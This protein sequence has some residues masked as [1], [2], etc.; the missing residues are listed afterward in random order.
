M[1]TEKESVEIAKKE[2]GDSV[3]PDAPIE[4]KLENNKYIVEF[5]SVL[6][7]GTRGTS[8]IRITIDANSGEVLQRLMDA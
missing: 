5:K 6:P 4:V 8:F 7:P 2:A 3:Q 1:I